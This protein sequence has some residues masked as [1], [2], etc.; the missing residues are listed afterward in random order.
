MTLNTNKFIAVYFDATEE[1]FITVLNKNK[2]VKMEI[3]P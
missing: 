3:G 2:E 1:I